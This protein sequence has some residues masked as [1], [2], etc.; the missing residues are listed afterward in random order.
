MYLRV[1]KDHLISVYS[2]EI[3][4][5]HKEGKSLETVFSK[6]KRQKLLFRTEEILKSLRLL[7]KEMKESDYEKE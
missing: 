5:E 1:R 7:E 6:N 2:P 3:E 4:I